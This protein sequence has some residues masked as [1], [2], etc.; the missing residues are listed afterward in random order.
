MANITRGTGKERRVIRSI[1]V[2]DTVGEATNSR[3]ENGAGAA[4]DTESGD[5][6]SAGGMF[7]WHELRYPDQ[8]LSSSSD[9]GKVQSQQRT[10]LDR[11]LGRHHH[12][13]PVAIATQQNESNTMSNTIER[14]S[15]AS[16][17]SYRRVQFGFQRHGT[18]PIDG[19]VEKK[20]DS[21]SSDDSGRGAAA[22]F[23]CRHLYLLLF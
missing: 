6:S 15:S 17:K 3:S 7:A 16:K 23:C 21:D 10:L 12:E 22:A 4:S 14:S 20:D 8:D 5:V 9:E 19:G 2:Y 13:P 11:L 1:D 18:K